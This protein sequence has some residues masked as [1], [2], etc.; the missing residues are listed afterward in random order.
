MCDINILI[1]LEIPFGPPIFTK[2]LEDCFIFEGNA[3]KFKC[4]VVGNPDPDVEWFK[5][6][7]K[8]FESKQ[9]T[10]LFDADDNCVLIITHGSSDTAGKITCVAKNSEGTVTSSSMLYV[11]GLVTEYESESED[12]VSDP[13]PLPEKDDVVIKKEE[14]ETYYTLKDE[15]GRYMI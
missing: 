1:F 12:E 3:A 11:E 7:E 6:G 14:I 10:M 4:C 2:E 5:D 9:F 13:E 15:L 8:L